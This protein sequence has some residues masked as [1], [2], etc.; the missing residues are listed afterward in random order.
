MGAGVAGLGFSCAMRYNDLM[1]V[2]LLKQGRGMLWNQLARFDISIVALE[3]WGKS[4]ESMLEVV[5]I[6]GRVHTGGSKRNGSPW[7]IEFNV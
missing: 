7:W 3:S 4:S 6:K 5:A 1:G 2:E